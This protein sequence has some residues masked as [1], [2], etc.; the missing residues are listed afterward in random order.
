M[1]KPTA[2][3]SEVT[4]HDRDDES[5]AELEY[6]QLTELGLL[7]VAARRDYFAAGG[8]PLTRDEIEREV[9]ERRGGTHLL[10]DQ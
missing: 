3:T 2:R 8:H 9:A 5:R 7:A 6:G 1:P 4:V 10:P